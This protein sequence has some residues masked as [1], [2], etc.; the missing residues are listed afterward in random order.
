MALG[1]YKA[2]I[3]RSKQKIEDQ[4]SRFGGD[5]I[6][7][8]IGGSTRRCHREELKGG[9]L[10]ALGLYKAVIKKSKQ[11]IEDQHA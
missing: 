4:D 8:G 1:Q 10:R 2:V 11:K 5:I 9:V 7:A 6:C 3:K